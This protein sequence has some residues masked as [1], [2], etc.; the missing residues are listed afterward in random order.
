MRVLISE[1]DLSFDYEYKLFE[2][3]NPV[4]QTAWK[5]L[6]ASWLFASNTTVPTGY[7]YNAQVIGLQMQSPRG[8]NFS[9]GGRP[10][11]PPLAL[12]T[13][14]G[15]LFTLVPLLPSCSIIR[16]RSKGDL[17]HGNK[18]VR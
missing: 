18:E 5:K 17:C 15:K 13:T 14:L 9:T 2:S 10:L 3:L 6:V 7:A 16:Y 12:V 11:P 1:Y 8:A 4:C